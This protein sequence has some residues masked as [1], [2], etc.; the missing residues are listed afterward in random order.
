MLD[1]SQTLEK[2]NNSQNFGDSTPENSFLQTVSNIGKRIKSI[3]TPKHHDT[4]SQRKFSDMRTSHMHHEIITKGISEPLSERPHNK[5]SPKLNRTDSRFSSVNN[6]VNLYS[7]SSRSRDIDFN[8]QREDRILEEFRPIDI[9]MFSNL[10]NAENLNDQS[11]FLSNNMPLDSPF[12]VIKSTAYSSSQNNFKRKRNP[13][14]NYD[15]LDSITNFHLTPME[16]QNQN[17]QGK[18]LNMSVSE[19]QE[20]I[21]SNLIPDEAKNLKEQINRISSINQGVSIPDKNIYFSNNNAPRN[22]P[23][24]KSHPT[25][26]MK[27][28]IISSYG[29]S[30][31][32]YKSFSQ[33]F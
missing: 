33:K 15:Q 9:S 25:E 8:S 3:L 4:V 10:K 13:S 14:L 26:K 6:S 19:S 31:S 22:E 18:S 7:N 32:T 27:P 24:K 30:N 12:S 1:E 5:K 29:L 16:N 21:S 20:Y 23:L 17:F 11:S 2:S 28:N